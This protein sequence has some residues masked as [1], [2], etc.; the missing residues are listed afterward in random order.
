MCFCI[1]PPAPRISCSKYKE[2][3]SI[4]GKLN[5]VTEVVAVVFVALLAT[6]AKVS[7]SVA[8][9]SRRPRRAADSGDKVVGEGSGSERSVGGGAVLVKVPDSTLHSNLLRK[10][11]YVIFFT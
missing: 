8:S 9:N 7:D 6:V 10:K 4:A 3:K 1:P 5:F 11:H 2:H